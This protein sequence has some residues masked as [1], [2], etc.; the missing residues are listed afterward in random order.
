MGA[1]K[2]KM[3]PVGG[4]G[5]R[6]AEEGSRRMVLGGRERGR[7]SVSLHSGRTGSAQHGPQGSH[8]EKKLQAP[9]PRMQRRERWR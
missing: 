3:G 7:Q 2:A 1:G 4:R 5:G 9:V 6:V 8:L